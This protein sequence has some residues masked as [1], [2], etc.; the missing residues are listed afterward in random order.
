MAT[1]MRAA[2]WSQLH[3]AGRRPRPANVLLAAGAAALLVG[4]AILGSSLAP[5]FDIAGEVP[6][7]AAQQVA[8]TR[9]TAA[10]R[11]ALENTIIVDGNRSAA[12]VIV[13][14]PVRGVAFT[15]RIP[16]LHYAAKVYEGIDAKTL[17]RGPGHYATSAWPGRDGTVGIAAHNVYWLKLN[18]LKIGDQIELQSALGLFLYRISGTKITAANDK[19]VLRPTDQQHR[20]VL[21]TC[22]PLWAGAYATRRLIF[23][24]TEIGA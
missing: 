6:G 5:M 1:N 23:F 19:S 10:A 14:R 22:Y 17:L 13:D 11:A 16:S 12:P 18:R 24:A 4:I 3:F 20:L 9:V 2:G 7:P 21:T 15:M 8:S